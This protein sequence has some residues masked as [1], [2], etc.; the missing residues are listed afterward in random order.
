MGTRVRW[1]KE[2]VLQV[3][4]TCENRTAFNRNYSGAYQ[5]ATKNGFLDEVFAVVPIESRG[6]QIFWTLER[7]CQIAGQYT[8]RVELREDHP[9]LYDRARADGVLDVVCQHIKNIQRI[10]ALHESDG[11]WKGWYRSYNAMK[12]R[13][14]DPESKFYVN[15]GGRGI[16]ICAR[17]LEEPLNFYEDMGDRPKGKTIDRIDVNG[18]YELANCR[19]ATASEQAGNKRNKRA[20]G[21]V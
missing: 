5:F 8:S 3:A 13:C 6:Q 18:N 2:M 9:G 11:T 19:W 15:Y 16:T 20:Y 7:M 12:Q 10:E 17:W 21:S 1:T 14:L 4:L